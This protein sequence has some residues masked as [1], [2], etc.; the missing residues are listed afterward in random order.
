[1]DSVG[2]AK[3]HKLPLPEFTRRYPIQKDLKAQIITS[4]SLGKKQ[5]KKNGIQ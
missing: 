4:K 3:L 5:N 2:F 1:M